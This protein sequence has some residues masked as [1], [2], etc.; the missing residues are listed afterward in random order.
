MSKIIPESRSRCAAHTLAEQLQQ[1]RDSE[2]MAA[3]RQRNGANDQTDITAMLE[4][5]MAWSGQHARL[6]MPISSAD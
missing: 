2:Q 3:Y 1:V 6:T 4:A 5:D